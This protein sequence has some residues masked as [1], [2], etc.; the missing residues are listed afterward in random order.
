MGPMGR[1]DMPGDGPGMMLPL[2]L[3]AVDLTDVQEKQIHAIMQAH[4]GTFRTLFG[5]LRA[6]QEDVTD[7]LFA[8]G[9]V[10]AED[11]TSQVQRVA[12][13]REQLLQEGLKVALEVRAVL[14]PEQLAKAAE[15]KDRMR[16]LRSEM[17]DLFREKK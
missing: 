3:R 11:L 7:K 17:R 2:V 6:A 13:L 12:Q 4:R 5:E 14:S 1:G 8:A 9:N 10:R 16:A 15:V